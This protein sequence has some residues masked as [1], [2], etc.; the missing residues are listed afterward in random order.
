MGSTDNDLSTPFRRQPDAEG[1]HRG[2]GGRNTLA[3]QT[4]RLLV[5]TE[6]HA[7]SGVRD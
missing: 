1:P 3:R 5:C 4:A 7:A 2:P 6:F